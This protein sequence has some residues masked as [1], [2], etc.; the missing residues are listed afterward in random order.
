ML[1]GQSG[2]GKSSLLNALFPNLEILTREVSVQTEKG[3]HTTAAARLYTMDNGIRVIDTPGIRQLGLW[4][5]SSE[6]LDYYFPDLAEFAGDCRFRNCT[7]QHE[8]DCAIREA[9]TNGRI[10]EV[11][12]HS[13]QRIREN[14]EESESY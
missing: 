14:L 12:F 8:P 7:H 13:Y 5:V 3:R 4:G 2:V 6:E 9:V 10:A 1:G 11:R